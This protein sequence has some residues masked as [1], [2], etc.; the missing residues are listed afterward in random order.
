MLFRVILGE[1]WRETTNP[2]YL[3][4]GIENV[5]SEPSSYT[6]SER[7]MDTPEG[8]QSSIGS[9]S[10][11]ATVDDLPGAG[12]T[13]DTYICQPAGKWIERLA[14]QFTISSLHPAWIAQYIEAEYTVFVPRFDDT[15]S[16]N[17]AVAYLCD[18]QW[19]G[20]II[21]AGMKGLVKQTQ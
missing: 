20:S 4:A 11:T 18:W 10:T 9:I 13:V 3:Y 6:H 8:D 5:F 14:M 15:Q 17:D 19:N 1:S 21:V 7:A 16:L 12:R 2:D